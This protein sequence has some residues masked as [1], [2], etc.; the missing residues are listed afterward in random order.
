MKF[1]AVEL[2]WA[3]LIAAFGMAPEECAAAGLDGRATCSSGG[4]RP[5]RRRIGSPMGGQLELAI[6]VG[7]DARV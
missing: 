5:C 2:D 7:L 3:V 6:R 1:S 4:G